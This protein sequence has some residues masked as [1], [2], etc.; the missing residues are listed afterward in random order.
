MKSNAFI[1]QSWII[2]LPIILANVA[3]AITPADRVITLS[4]SATEMAYAAGM[5]IIL[6]ELVLT[7]IIRRR[8]KY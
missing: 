7:L 5:E 8:L 1:Y 4:P 3:I 2:T 6:S